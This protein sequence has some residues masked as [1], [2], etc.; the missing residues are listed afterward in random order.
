MTTDT[1]LITIPI[2]LTT[3]QIARAAQIARAD[4]AISNDEAL[5]LAQE[6]HDLIAVV[7]AAYATHP[8]D[9]TMLVKRLPR[10][11]KHLP[12]ETAVAY[13]LGDLI[14][15]MRDTIFGHWPGG[16]DSNETGD[17]SEWIMDRLTDL[18]DGDSLFVRYSR[19][20]D[21][22]QGTNFTAI[23]TLDEDGDG[24]ALVPG[25]GSGGRSH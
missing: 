20:A 3:S 7:Q 16:E 8:P 4:Q 12:Y 13:E 1:I 15:S 17:L 2:A 22:V 25:A 19:L 11:A 14:D 10:S 21:R 5:E 24:A 23:L 6:M 9:K 18:S